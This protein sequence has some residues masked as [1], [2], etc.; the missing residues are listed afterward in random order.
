MPEEPENHEQHPGEPVEETPP[1]L[2]GPPGLA[3]ETPPPGASGN[4]PRRSWQSID[5]LLHNPSDIAAYIRE[6]R[7]LWIVSASLFWYT[8]ALA[9]FYGGVMGAANLLQGADLPFAVKL[10]QIGVT[11]VK[12]PFLFLFALVVVLP[13]VYV[14]NAFVGSHNS[15]RQVVAMLV[16]AAATTVTVLASMGTV[17]FFFALTSIS[18]TFIVLMHV[19]FFAYAGLIGIGFLQRCISMMGN[20]SSVLTPNRLLFLW[21][22]LYGFVGTQLAWVLR[23]FVGNPKI[24]YTIFRPREGNFYEAVWRSLVEFT[25]F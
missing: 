4:F 21:L 20:D 11:S 14:S 1:P 19:A 10:M 6:D 25:G 3:A 15:L 12:V 17:A 2:P 5:Y 7:D 13:P 23:P 16:C 22:C 9:S 24:P 8:C 18:Y